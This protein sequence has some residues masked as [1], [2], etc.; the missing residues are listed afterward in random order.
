MTTIRV[1][2]MVEH[3]IEEPV[4]K[5]ARVNREMD[6]LVYILK[7]FGYTLVDQRMGGLTN[8]DK[9]GFILQRDF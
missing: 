2:L 5:G 3:E 8:D 9:T 7:G 1:E 4:M 6:V